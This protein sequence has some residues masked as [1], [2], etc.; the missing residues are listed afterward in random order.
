LSLSKRLPGEFELI[1]RYFAPLS[2]G[3]AGAFGLT[4]D[5]AVISPTAGHELVL[6]SDAIVC[7][8][9]FQVDDPADLV[10]RKA[11]RV[12][13]SD[14][15]AKGAEPRAY[16]LDLALPG[17]TDEA[18]VAAFAHGLAEDQKRYQI[19][20]IG[21]DTDS[22]PGPITIAISAFG[23]ID[24]GRMIRRAG[25]RAGD[26]IFVTGTIGDA[27]F[28]LRVLRGE[29]RGVGATGA[30]FLIDRYRLPQPRV[31]LGPKLV[32]LATA[33]I[34]ISDGLLADLR[35]ICDVS[36]LCARIEAQRVPLSEA[37]R[38]ALAVKR[39]LIALVLSG[40]DDYEILFTAPA[41]VT[42]GVMQL[43]KNLDVPITEIGEMLP[44]SAQEEPVEAIDA[45]GRA[46]QV[47]SEGWR[48]F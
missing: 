37:A 13:L 2:A 12:N 19:H 20:L 23:E 6:K 25:A 32:G 35:H 3:F 34:D 38:T 5:A 24:A 28:G 46:L 4:D 30:Q 16:M 45:A 26:K 15:A 42:A 1:A 27:A 21:G 29:L 8:V 36:E 33:A 14:L 10:A 17:T 39:D 9:H 41:S 48:H 18:W 43:S 22:T 40:G 44:P 47:E 31:S 7:G 11:L